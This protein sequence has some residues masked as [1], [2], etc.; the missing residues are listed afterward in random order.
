LASA[1]LS[2]SSQEKLPEKVRSLMH[3][4]KV[5][6]GHARV[7]IGRSEAEELTP[8]IVEMGL[9]VLPMKVSADEEGMAC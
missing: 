7:L 6:A 9:S 8:E 1:C 2:L 3:S 4:G 5:S